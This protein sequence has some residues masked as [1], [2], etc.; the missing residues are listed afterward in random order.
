MNY[1][2]TWTENK[3]FTCSHFH[4]AHTC[5]LWPIGP[6][7]LLFNSWKLVHNKWMVTQQA[8]TSFGVL[9]GNA[10]LCITSS[11]KYQYKTKENKG[12]IAIL[13]GFTNWGKNTKKNQNCLYNLNGK[14]HQLLKHKH[15]SWHWNSCFPRMTAAC[16]VAENSSRLTQKCKLKQNKFIVHTISGAQALRV[17]CTRLQRHLVRKNIPVQAHIKVRTANAMRGP[18]LLQNST[19]QQAKNAD[20]I[21]HFC[22]NDN[23]F[24]LHILNLQILACQIMQNRSKHMHY[25]TSITSPMC[26]WNKHGAT[27][28]MF[29]IGH[30]TIYRIQSKGAMQKQKMR[31][32]TDI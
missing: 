11:R 28:L 6:C 18:Q 30:A 27:Q 23:C 26:T 2:N 31:M 19:Q 22:F 1:S 15:N 16:E 7:Q 17:T 8:Q 14:Q 10:L 25:L 5:G 20:T 32:T 3:L 21:N 9:S 12:L 4:W 29:G 24:A 13:D